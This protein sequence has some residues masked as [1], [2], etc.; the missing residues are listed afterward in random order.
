M[1]MASYS[2]WAAQLHYEVTQPEKD[3]INSYRRGHQLAQQANKP[4][5]YVYRGVLY[6][7]NAQK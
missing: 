3:R 1:G 5:T 6:T 7:K 4:G 2:R